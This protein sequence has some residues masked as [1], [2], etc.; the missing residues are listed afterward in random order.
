MYD[1]VITYDEVDQL[2]PSI[3][4]AMVDMAGNA[5]VRAAVHT[6]FTDNL[7]ASLTVGVTHWE[8]PNSAPATLPGPEPE[9]FFAP[10]QAAKRTS[11]WGADELN[12]RL[13]RSFHQMLNH[14]ERWLTVEIHSGPDG[15]AQVHN[16]LLEGLASPAVGFVVRL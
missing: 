5:N 11:D 10:A 9:F 8:E 12:S 16:A 14:A 13:A 1:E 3:V 6:H 7:K 4:S 15:V 2:D